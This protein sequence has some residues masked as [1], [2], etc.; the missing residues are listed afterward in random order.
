MLGGGG[1]VGLRELPRL[2]PLEHCAALTRTTRTLTRR[3]TAS[4]YTYCGSTY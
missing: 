1:A 4:G 3:R 2:P